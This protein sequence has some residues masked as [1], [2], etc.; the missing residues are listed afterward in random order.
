MTDQPA[1]PLIDPAAYAAARPALMK[2]AAQEEAWAQT[3]AA[4]ADFVAA[5]RSFEQLL[6]G[7]NLFLLGM[8]LAK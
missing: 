4:I 1:R 5:S 2:L 7:L 6:A 3:R 8:S